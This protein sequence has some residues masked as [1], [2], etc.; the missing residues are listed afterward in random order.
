MEEIAQLARGR[1]VLGWCDNMTAVVAINTGRCKSD[2]V[3]RLVRWL[4]IL[5]AEHDIQ[6]WVC[7]IAGEI[8]I[9]PDQLSRGVLG[10]R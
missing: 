10:G 4:H 8:N 7:H 5:C 2:R 3:L 6:L 9:V 1:R